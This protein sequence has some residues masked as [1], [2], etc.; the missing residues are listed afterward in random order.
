MSTNVTLPALGES[1]SEGTVSRWLK[2]VGDTV[3][4]DEPLD[5]LARLLGGDG[6]AESAGGTV[7][8]AEELELVGADPGAL[9]EQLHAAPAHLR[10]ALVAQQLE[11][12]AERPDGAQHVMTQAGTEQRGK[13]GRRSHSGIPLYEQ[14]A[15]RHQTHPVTLPAPPFSIIFKGL[16]RIGVG[17]TW[18]GERSKTPFGVPHTMP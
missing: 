12:V 15:G 8:Q 16:Q 17:D 13:V 2:K 6:L 14:T 1:V 7:G 4:A 10:I 5:E 3:A 11:P 9:F 18:H